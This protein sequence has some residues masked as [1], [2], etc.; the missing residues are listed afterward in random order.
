MLKTC[1]DC[2]GAMPGG[3]DHLMRFFCCCLF[4]YYSTPRV[5]V[6][7]FMR[8]ACPAQ[9]SLLLLLWQ[10]MKLERHYCKSLAFEVYL[11]AICQ[12]VFKPD[13]A[14]Q[15]KVTDSAQRRVPTTTLYFLIKCIDTVH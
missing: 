4:L 13:A 14:A 1:A 12:Q 9:G 15:I 2:R 10:R 6:V 3:G 11:S 7:I 5:V 8:F